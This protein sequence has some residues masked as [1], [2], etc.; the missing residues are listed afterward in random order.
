MGG[1]Q[2]LCDDALVSVS[3]GTQRLVA[4]VALHD[5]PVARLR[6]AG[7]LWPDT[8]E[9]RA[10]ANLRS[11]LCRLKRF[12][13]MVIDASGGQLAM[14]PGAEVDVWQLREL[15]S[16]A[17]R[18]SVDVRADRLD[19]L[20]TTGELLPG[21]FDEWVINER[22]RFRMLRIH[23]LEGMCRV[24]AEVGEFGRAIDACLVVVGEEPLRESAHRALIT[25]HLLQGNR[26]DALRQ[27]EAYRRMMHDD[28]GLEPSSEMRQLVRQLS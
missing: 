16:S 13:C 9:A 22:E 17:V 24:L 11:A 6:V 14:A 25:A 15:V 19:A 28:L 4:Y 10:L 20:A 26:G 21:W 3:E 2:L 18:A 27:F 7:A 5:R 8:T 1:F 23:V 12:D